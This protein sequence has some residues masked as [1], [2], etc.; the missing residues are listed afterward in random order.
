MRGAG[1][2]GWVKIRAS[3]AERA[4]WHAKVERERTRQVARI[5]T[6]LNQIARWTTA[7]ALEPAA[8]ELPA[9]RQDPPQ[10]QMQVAED[11]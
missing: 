9:R 2:D 3:Q 10:R 11:R 8:V 5:G 7:Y 4:E 6:N 1:R